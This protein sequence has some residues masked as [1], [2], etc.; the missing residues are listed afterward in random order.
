MKKFSVKD[1][2]TH[3]GPCFS[4]RQPIKLQIHSFNDNRLGQETHLMCQVQNNFTDVELLHTY[5]GVL[6]LTVDHKTNQFST[7]NLMGLREYLF[8]HRLALYC[9][10]R[11]CSTEMA[12]HYLDFD[13]DKQFIKA[14]SIKDEQ[15]LIEDK[16]KLYQV[17][18]HYDDNHTAIFIC[19]IGQGATMFRLD[20]PLLPRAKFKNRE[21]LIQKLK[22]YLLF[23]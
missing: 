3:N 19:N 22:N 6:K 9:H 23:S 10:C 20:T 8:T 15:I 17:Y 21:E 12:S 7:S 16:D 4:C 14:V 13:F 2:I 11:C 5:H 18:S 1:F